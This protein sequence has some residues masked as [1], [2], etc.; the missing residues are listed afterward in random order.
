VRK[1]GDQLRA[2]EY[3]TVDGRPI[4]ADVRE[5]D[6]DEGWVEIFMPVI[7]QTKTVS[8]DD[9]LPDESEPPNTLDWEVKLLKGKI[10]VKTM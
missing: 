9:R 1:Q 4:M 5:F 2:N 6:T 8:R 3:V 7:S 10:E